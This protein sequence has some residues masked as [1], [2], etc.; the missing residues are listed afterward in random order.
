MIIMVFE[1]SIFTEIYAAAKET[2]AL[3]E[4]RFMS[5]SHEWQFDNAWQEMLNH[6]TIKVFFLF[7]LLKFTTYLILRVC[8]DIMYYFVKRLWM[9]KNRKRKAMLNIN[10]KRIYLATLK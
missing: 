7:I 5:N 4:Q 8:N 2:V 9:P 6:A 1:F 3:A 10:E